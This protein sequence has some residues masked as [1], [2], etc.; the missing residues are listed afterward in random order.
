MFS[1]VTSS[2][3]RSVDFKFCQN[4]QLGQ[5]AVCRR[6][7]PANR[8]RDSVAKPAHLGPHF[9]FRF[10]M[11]SLITPTLRKLLY[12]AKSKN[13]GKLQIKF[14]KISNFY[15]FYCLLRDLL[16]KGSQ[17]IGNKI[18]LKKTRFRERSTTFFKY[19]C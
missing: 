9:R 3:T 14:I 12:T 11:T 2:E 4:L 1:A 7:F 10:H 15:F 19:F 16:L 13:K 6:P 8:K 17:R 18:S 5:P